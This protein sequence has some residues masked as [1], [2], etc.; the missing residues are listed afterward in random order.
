MS[1]TSDAERCDFCRTGTVVEHAQQ[2]SFRQWT[3]KGYV[4]CCVDIPMG[5]CDHCQAQHWSA[6]AETI[7]KEAVRREYEK[8]PAS[9]V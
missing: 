9:K 7:V 6:D 4:F 5:V 1:S 3:D 8:L 2:V